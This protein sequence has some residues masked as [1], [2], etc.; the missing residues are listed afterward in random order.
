MFSTKKNTEIDTDQYEM[1]KYAEKRV[2]TKKRLYYHFVL[3]LL[4]SVL[5]I[6]LNK[7]FHYGEQYWEDWF[8]IAITIWAFFFVFHLIQVFITKRFM[9][10]SW[11]Q[12]Q[13]SKLVGNQKERIEKL[14]ADL[15]KEEVLMAESEV[16]NEQL[17]KK[18]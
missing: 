2:K 18:N 4:G 15:K 16:F 6:V 9:N 3:F 11:E 17:K 12:A 5:L 13:I 7:V 10:K 14:K 8:V 1:I